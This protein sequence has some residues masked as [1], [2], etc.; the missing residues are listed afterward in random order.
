M[1]RRCSFRVSHLTVLAMLRS[2][3]TP[4]ARADANGYR[5]KN[6]S[7]PMHLN[8][9]FIS[10]RSRVPCTCRYSSPTALSHSRRR[11]RRRRTCRD[12]VGS[13]RR[14]NSER[15]WIVAGGVISHLCAPKFYWKSTAAA[16]VYG[17]GPYGPRRLEPV[18]C[19]RS[20]AVSII[21]IRI[22][23]TVCCN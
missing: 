10:T 16:S 15:S 2:R 8:R 13:R 21:T 17:N 7:E 14:S 3:R 5:C 11:T 4:S 20:H 23:S 18:K 19:R 22:R 12:I 9:E 1:F 6:L